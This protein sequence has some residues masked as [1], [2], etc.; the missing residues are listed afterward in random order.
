[1][2]KA[3][4]SI[5]KKSKQWLEEGE[6]SPV[7]NI[8]SVPFDNNYE[9]LRAGHQKLVQ[10]SLCAKK[11]QYAWGV[12]QGAALAKVL[13]MERISVIE[14]GVAGGAGLLAL[15]RIAEHCQ[16][17]VDIGIEVYGFDTGTGLPKPSDYRDCPNFW[18]EGQYPVDPDRLQKRLRRAC[19]KLGSVQDTVP[20]FIDA[21]PPPVAF[22]SFDL[23]LYTSTRDALRLF[24]AEYDLLL[25]RIISYFDDII[26]T[27]VSDYTGERLAI[28]EFNT[29]HTMRKLSPIYGLQHY[30]TPQYKGWTWPEKMYFAH[31]FDHPLHNA[32]DSIHKPMFIDIEG[33]E[34]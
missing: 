30:V 23:D 25:P 31:F 13:G 26:G 28:S 1:M 5:L 21:E 12:L 6:K 10:D 11:P 14:F 32:P 16:E 33:N 2:K 22:V 27:T 34:A 20:T 7:P 24:K 17:L 4:K 18:R 29:T 3:L 15:E 9:W 8:P 19:L